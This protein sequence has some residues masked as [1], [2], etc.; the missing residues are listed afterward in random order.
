MI[1]FNRPMPSIRTIP[2]IP[3]AY[4]RVDVT[5]DLLEAHL[6]RWQEM[7]LD[8]NPDFQREHVWTDAQRTAYVEWMLRGGESGRELHFNCPWW[9]RMQ[10]RRGEYRDFVIVDGK[11]RLEAVRRFLRDELLA[12][13]Y[14]R[15]Q[16]VEKDLPWDLSFS[17]RVCSL[18]TRA[19]VLAWYLDFNS[20]GTPHTEAELARVRKLLENA[21]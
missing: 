5:W 17:F 20:G 3:R 1:G 6:A 12:F 8:L 9:Q 18:D 13:G 10:A 15:S 14:L 19:K 4:Y 2:Q 7:G 16:Y 21:P 11:Q